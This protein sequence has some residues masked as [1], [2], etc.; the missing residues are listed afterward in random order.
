MFREMR[1]SKQKLSEKDTYY[2]LKKGSSGVLALHGDNSYPYG[3]APFLSCNLFPK[4]N[5]YFKYGS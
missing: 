4:N 3:S 2:L 5:V 1:R